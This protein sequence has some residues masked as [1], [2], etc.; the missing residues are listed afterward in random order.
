MEELKFDKQSAEAL[1]RIFCGLSSSCYQNAEVY[2]EAKPDMEKVYERI[3]EWG[4]KNCND[5]RGEKLNSVSKA[6]TTTT[7]TIPFMQTDI[8]G[9]YVPPPAYST[10]NTLS[11]SSY[12]FE[13]I[14]EVN[15]ISVDGIMQIHV[16]ELERC[17]YS[18]YPQLI[19]EKRVCKKIYVAKGNDIVLKQTIYGKYFP[20]QII[21]SYFEF[22]EN[23]NK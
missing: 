22:D 12:V 17:E 16:I 8:K 23:E 5:M 15:H 1:Y 19:P 11:L 18:I 9:G 3:L 14:L 2:D 20:Q 13:K 4:R 10:S 21:E 6:N 7:I